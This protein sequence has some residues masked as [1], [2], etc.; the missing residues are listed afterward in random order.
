M[1]NNAGTANCNKVE[2]AAAGDFE[3]LMRVNYLSAVAVTRAVLPF[4]KKEDATTERKH[5]A[6][7]S[8]QVGPRDLAD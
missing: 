5:I 1:V 8:S 3:Q 4:M 2:D 7:V 6:F